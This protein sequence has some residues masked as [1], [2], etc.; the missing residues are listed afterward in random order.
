MPK[1]F[2]ITAKLSSKAKYL[3]NAVTE[4]P[5]QVYSPEFSNSAHAITESPGQ[6]FSW[7]SSDDH[8]PEEAHQL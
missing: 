7:G 4:S 5:R 3:Q 8:S 1:I 6:Y 2:Q